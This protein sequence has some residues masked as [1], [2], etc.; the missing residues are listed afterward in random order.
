MSN[1][2]V[3]TNKSVMKFCFYTHETYS[4]FVYRMVYSSSR[5]EE[6]GQNEVLHNKL[7]ISSGFYLDLR[8]VRFFVYSNRN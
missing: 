2:D 7:G 1:E 5:I 4:K 8:T 3:P 6:N